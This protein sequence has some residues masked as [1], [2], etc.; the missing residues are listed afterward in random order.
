MLSM[1]MLQMFLHQLE[2]TGGVARVPP[3]VHRALASRACHSAIR[4]AN[5]LQQRLAELWR[6]SA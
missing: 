3:G 6:A 1:R 4:C 2:R 5:F